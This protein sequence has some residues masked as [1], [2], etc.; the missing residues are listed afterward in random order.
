MYIIVY[1]MIFLFL[2][3]GVLLFPYVEDRT[4]VDTIVDV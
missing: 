2:G 1:I 4:A 3:L